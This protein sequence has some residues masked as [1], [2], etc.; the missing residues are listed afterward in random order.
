ME[1]TKMKANLFDKTLIRILSYF[2]ISPGSRYRR[3][4]LKE[5]TEMNNVPLDATLNKLS[6]LGILKEKRNIYGLNLENQDIHLLLNEI[7]KEYDEFHLPY[8]IYNI[9]VEISEK[10]TREKDIA[11]M[12]L[13]GSYAKLIHTDKSDIDIAVILKDSI[14]NHS[15]IERRLQKEMEKIEKRHNKIIEL[16]FFHEKEMKQHDPIIKDILRNGKPLW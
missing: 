9:L 4:E 13:F 12:I 16:H 1:E 11:Q 15:V 6:V 7:K 3:K 10:A 5:K 2:I 14:K 8:A